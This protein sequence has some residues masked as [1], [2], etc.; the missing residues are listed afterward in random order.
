MKSGAPTTNRVQF[1]SAFTV[2]LDALQFERLGLQLL[3]DKGIGGDE[4]F[5]AP[6][7]VLGML[8][9]GSRPGGSSHRVEF[10]GIGDREVLAHSEVIGFGLGDGVEDRAAGRCNVF[11]APCSDIGCVALHVPLAA[12]HPEIRGNPVERSVLGVALPRGAARGC[13]VLPVLLERRLRRSRRATPTLGGV[14]EG[15][16]VPALHLRTG[17]HR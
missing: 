11:A 6:A 2:E 16:G 1:V 13:D 5:C 12:H 8:G 10:A 14:V 3:T 17:R 7:N 15:G 9:R 4:L